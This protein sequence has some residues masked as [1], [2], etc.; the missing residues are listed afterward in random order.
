MLQWSGDGCGIVVMLVICCVVLQGNDRVRE[1]CSEV[2]VVLVVL[3]CVCL[4]DVAG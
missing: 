1:G 2:V 4:C 3:V